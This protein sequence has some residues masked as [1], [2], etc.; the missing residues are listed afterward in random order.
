MSGHKRLWLLLVGVLLGTFTLLGFMGREVYRQ[1]PPIPA[2]VVRCTE[3]P[4][5]RVTTPMT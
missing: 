3:R 4:R 1:A 2:R 5:P